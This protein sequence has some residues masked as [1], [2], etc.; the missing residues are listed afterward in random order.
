MSALQEYLRDQHGMMVSKDDINRS[1]LPF[2]AF[3][4]K[5]RPALFGDPILHKKLGLADSYRVVTGSTGVIH[6][7]YDPSKVQPKFFSQHETS[8][9]EH[10]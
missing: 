6:K 5:G 8:V 1:T 7:S 4:E 10:Y 9:V 3:D 2:L